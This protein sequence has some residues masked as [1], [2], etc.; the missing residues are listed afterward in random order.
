MIPS[1][2]VR[3]ATRKEGFIDYKNPIQR[4]KIGSI[5]GI[6]GIIFNVL[7]TIMKMLIGYFTNSISIIADGFN[8]LT[9]AISSLVAALGMAYA[10]RASDENHPHGH[11]RMEY[12]STLT[13]SVVILFVGLSLIKSSIETLLNPK[14]IQFSWVSLVVLLISVGMKYWMYLFYNDISKKIDSTTLKASAVDS[15]SDVMV[16]SIVILAFF[17]SNLSKLPVDAIG[18]IIV[19]GFILKS[20]YELILEMV[21][22]LVSESVDEEVLKEIY[23]IFD[24]RKEI[25]DTHDLNF[26]SYGPNNKYATIDAVVSNDMTVEEVHRVF[27]EIEHA[28]LDRFQIMMTIHMDLQEEDSKEEKKL[29]NILK[30]CK[31][32]NPHILST[33]DEE[34][35]DQ[36]DKRN[37]IAHVVVDGNVIKTNE[38]EINEISKL[39]SILKEEF[40]DCEYHIFIDK[41][42]KNG[43]N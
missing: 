41:D 15:I 11:G 29:I 14:E 36:E 18:G 6:V 1:L 30:K 28:I 16:T 38:D 26:H 9:D 31:L 3:L 22:E 2:I 13:I 27:T 42:Y 43:N 7:I 33:H 24:E 12:L 40:G 35:I 25:V 37:I 20:G 5:T 23:Q 32:E 17:L 19:S 34:I 21:R 8:N 10:G 4:A 39:K